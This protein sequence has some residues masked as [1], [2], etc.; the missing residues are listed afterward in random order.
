MSDNDDSV[1]VSRHHTTDPRQMLSSSRV[2]VATP[3]SVFDW[4]FEHGRLPSTRV[5]TC[6]CSLT[7]CFIIL[8]VIVLEVGV[9]MK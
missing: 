9:I 4:R 8:L 3:L 2:L 7:I 1:E 6:V 5:F